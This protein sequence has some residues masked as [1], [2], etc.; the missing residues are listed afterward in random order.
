MKIILS[1][2]EIKAVTLIT[3]NKYSNGS[4]FALTFLRRIHALY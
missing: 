1:L 4:S 2:L 3:M